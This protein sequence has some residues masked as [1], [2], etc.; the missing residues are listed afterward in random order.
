M[1]PEI[2]TYFAQQ[3]ITTLIYDTRSFGESDGQLRRELDLAKQ[4]EDYSDALSFLTS[5]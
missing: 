4:V 1:L 3:G 2:A 5:H